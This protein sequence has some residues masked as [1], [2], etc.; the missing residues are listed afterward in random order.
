V[1]VKNDATPTA[2]EVPVYNSVPI[3]SQLSGT[4][5]QL[6]GLPG[7]H[8]VRVVATVGSVTA[9]ASCAVPVIYDRIVL[10]TYDPT[11]PGSISTDYPTNMELWVP[12]G[13]TA[14]ATDNGLA[15]SRPP[16]ALNQYFA[17]IDYNNNAGPYKNQGG[18][19][20]GTYYVLVTAGSD[21][22][23]FGYGIRVLT[24]PNSSYDGWTFTPAITSEPGT[25]EPMS[26]PPPSTN[27]YQAM[28][29][30]NPPPNTPPDRLNRFIVLLP[31]GIHSGVNWMKL[32]LP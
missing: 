7:N 29:V 25:D 26:G 10:D 14:M 15:S 17:Y 6:D 9:E 12:G 28:Q 1:F 30:N 3:S 13:T 21:G 8:H 2:A 22:D 20:P 18:L 11:K 31:D 4:L 24:A 16:S 32:I 27:N 5:A 23:T 19:A